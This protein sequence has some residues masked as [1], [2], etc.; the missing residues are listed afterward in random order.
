MG[1]E[2]TLRERALPLKPFPEVSGSTHV[3]AR[4]K[5]DE[6]TQRISLKLKRSGVSACFGHWS[7]ED[8]MGEFMPHNEGQ[9]IVIRRKLD[10]RTADGKVPIVGMGLE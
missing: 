9:F 1:P 7:S 6:R 4:A 3:I 10:K 5:G 2:P 8:A